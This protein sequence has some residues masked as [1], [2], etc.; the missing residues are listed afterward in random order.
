MNVTLRIVR[1]SIEFFSGLALAFT[2]LPSV[3]EAFTGSREVP[4]TLAWTVCIVAAGLLA[5]TVELLSA[6]PRGRR[7][8]SY[9]SQKFVDFY[10]DWYSAAGK[11]SVFCDDT[12][13]LESRSRAPI[14][15]ALRDKGERASLFVRATTGSVIPELHKAGVNIIEIPDTVS[16]EA[17]LSLRVEDG[18]KLLII[19]DSR[20]EARDTRQKKN[21]F[22][23]TA[24]A[25]LV[26]LAE[27]LLRAIPRKVGGG[28]D[29]ENGAKAH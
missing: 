2:I 14:V 29:V 7:V 17:R 9:D 13:W 4:V 10:A 15:A 25:N 21:I 16:L 18:K 19:R 8:L 22:V 5:F 24:D 28:L 26:T 1:F 12:D 20:A 6:I 11:V 3:S 27:D 23:Q